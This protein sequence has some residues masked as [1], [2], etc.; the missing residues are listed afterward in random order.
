MQQP[1]LHH[2]AEKQMQ[3]IQF[4]SP[5]PSYIFNELDPE[6]V[7][8]DLFWG[9]NWEASTSA[10]PSYPRRLISMF[11]TNSH[12]MEVESSGISIDEIVQLSDDSSSSSDA[13]SAPNEDSARFAAA[14]SHC[15]TISLFQ[16]KSLPRT[17]QS[18]PSTIAMQPIFVDK[19]LMTEQI[20]VTG[21]NANTQSSATT[22]LEIVPWGPILHV[23]ALQ[24]QPYVNATKRKASLQTSTPLIIGEDGVVHNPE[25]SP[26]SFEFQTQQKRPSPTK[27]MGQNTGQVRQK[28][29]NMALPEVV[30]NSDARTPLV[31][32]NVR[33]SSRLSVGKEGYCSVRIEKESSKRSKNWVVQIDEATGEA[34]PISIDIL[35]GWGIKCGVDPSDLTE[36]ALMQAPPTQVADVDDTE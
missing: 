29:K 36:D 20:A 5:F 10:A 22:G 1:A 16:R 3:Q 21:Q 28:R 6:S 25:S 2:Y 35:Q 13:S 12:A 24:A 26:K 32:K 15:A 31:Q 27:V 18:G 7:T 33:R 4:K 23:L 9:N 11:T 19:T 34:G 14:R 8:V 30:S 17:S